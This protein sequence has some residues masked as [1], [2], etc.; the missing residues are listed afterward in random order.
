M[1]EKQLINE[2]ANIGNIAVSSLKSLSAL[3]AEIIA[4]WVA[5]ESRNG[6]DMLCVDVGYG[7]L[8]I[9]ICEGS[10][11]YRFEPSKRL[12][13]EISV[14]LNGGEL[15]LLRTLETAVVKKIENTYRDVIL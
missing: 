1:V 4:E 12:T 2:M 3:S 11:K 14:S 9:A 6:E 10:V 13:T 8:H 5:E 7:K 15:P